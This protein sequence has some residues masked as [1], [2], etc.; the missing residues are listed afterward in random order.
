[1]HFPEFL[2]TIGREKNLPILETFKARDLES[3][4]YRKYP[5][6][7]NDKVIICLHGSGSHGAYLHHLAQYLCRSR[8]GIRT[9]FKGA[10]WFGSNSRRL[11]LHRAIRG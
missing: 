8:T 10:L 11:R 1:M 3:L 4:S 2:K 9:E 7:Y 5:S 6:V